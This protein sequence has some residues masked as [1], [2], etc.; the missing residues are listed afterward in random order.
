MSGQ[1]GVLDVTYSVEQ[2]TDIIEWQWLFPPFAIKGKFPDIL[3]DKIKGPEAGKLL[4]KAKKILKENQS[5]FLLKQRL[6][7][8][9]ARGDGNCVIFEANDGKEHIFPFLRQQESGR[10]S[11]FCYADNFDI[12]KFKGENYS[13]KNLLGMFSS[14]VKFIGQ[15]TSC[16]N[17]SHKEAD[18]FFTI[19]TEILCG[20]LAE[21]GAQL[22][23]ADFLKK[24]GAKGCVRPAPGYKS[25]PDHSL[26]E[27]IIESLGGEDLCQIN[28]V[29]GY[30]MDPPASTAGIVIFDEQAGYPSIQYIGNDQF[31][32]YAGKRGVEKEK[33]KRALNLR[34]LE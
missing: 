34:I 18:P 26:K 10:D 15:D 7:I 30:M 29:E 23:E 27:I 5:S 21:A 22:M 31:E 4:N 2:L 19:L 20:R 13:P 8:F 28:L 9:A 14:S 25:L 33:L 24:S 11:H 6:A 3:D 1:T 12:H 17:T 16:D 32:Y